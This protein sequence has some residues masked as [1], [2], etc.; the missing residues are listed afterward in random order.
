MEFKQLEAFVHVVNLSSFSK[1]ADAIFLSQP[2]VSAYISSLEKELGVQLIFRSTK[3]VLP[4]KAG[5]LFHEYASNILVL[6]DKAIFTVKNLSLNAIGQSE[7]LASSVPSQYILPEVLAEF[8]KIYPGISFN[9]KQTDS[10][11]VVNGVISQ[12]SEFGIA[13]TKII[14]NKCIYEPFMSD[15]LILIAP[16]EERFKIKD[17]HSLID[18]LKNEFFIAREQGSGTK[19]SYEEFIKNLGISID[20]LKISATFFNTQ[21]IIHSVSKGLGISIVSELAAK[22]YIDQNLVLKINTIETLPKR[23]FYFIFKKDF[24]LSH[25]CEIFVEFARNYFLE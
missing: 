24:M 7:I 5:K 8:H 21:S 19:S 9:V 1:A 12:K 23:D 3:E 14:N 4:T 25:I 10:L 18:L 16:N 15:K 11:E 6:R 22:Q 17:K 2:S 20:K 13:G